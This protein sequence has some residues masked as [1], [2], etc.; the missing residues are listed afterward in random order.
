KRHSYSHQWQV[1]HYRYPGCKGL[2]RFTTSDASPRLSTKIGSHSAL[3]RFTG[4]E[5]VAAGFVVLT[6]GTCCLRDYLGDHPCVV[7]GQDRVASAGKRT[8][9]SQSSLTNRGSRCCSLFANSRRRESPDARE[10]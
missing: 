3:G 7:L 5:R 8:N 1:G 6:K 4:S 10:N 9:C 2:R